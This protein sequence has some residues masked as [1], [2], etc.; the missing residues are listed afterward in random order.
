MPYWFIV[1][2]CWWWVAP[3]INSLNHDSPSTS[4]PCSIGSLP[5]NLQTAKLPGP[6]RPLPLLMYNHQ[7]FINPPTVSIQTQ[8]TPNTHLTNHFKQSFCRPN[9]TYQR[10]QPV[11]VGPYCYGLD[12]AIFF[13]ILRVTNQPAQTTTRPERHAG[14]D[15]LPD[16]IGMKSP[17]QLQV[18]APLRMIGC[19][20]SP[21]VEISSN[22]SVCS[23]LNMWS[24]L[25]DALLLHKW[26]GTCIWW[27]RTP[28]TQWFWRKIYI[29]HLQNQ[30]LTSK[31]A[32]LFL[33]AVLWEILE[34]H[35][36]QLT[37]N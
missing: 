35:Q 22:T 23:Y 17:Q 1:V 21:Y 20:P 6:P 3:Q 31:V 25:G 34:K 32:K 36:C 19:R 26:Q 24:Y 37:W 30:N 10:T 8:T 28:Y 11:V 4:V 12:I 27:K 13:R 29:Q 2:S 16:W 9:R 15:V 5:A 14:P 18:R 7:P 33:E